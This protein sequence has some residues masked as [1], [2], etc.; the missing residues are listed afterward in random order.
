MTL[1]R[2]LQSETTLDH[3]NMKKMLKLH[4]TNLDLNNMSQVEYERQFNFE[5]TDKKAKA[6]LIK[7]TERK[8]FEVEHKQ[9]S[10][11]LKFS[12]GAYVL[13]AKP[14]IN[15][16]QAM[17]NKK[18][19]FQEEDMV[20]CVTEYKDGMDLNNKHVDTKIVLSVNSKKVV[21]H[22]YNST[23]NIKIDGSCYLQF[24][25][26][27]LAPTIQSNIDKLSTKISEYDRKVH[28]SLAARGRPLRP[29]SVKTVRSFINQPQFICKNCDKKFDNHTQLKKHK[30]TEHSK[31]FISSETSVSYIKHSTRNNSIAEEML[32]C[33]DIT[34]NMD[35]KTL[36]EENRM[37]T[38]VPQKDVNKPQEDVFKQLK[39]LCLPSPS[40]NLYEEDVCEDRKQT[41]KIVEDIQLECIYSCDKCDFESE[42]KKELEVHVVNNIHNVINSNKSLVDLNNV[43]ACNEVVHC[44]LCEHTTNDE[45]SMKLH[46]KDVHGIVDCK[47]CDYSAEDQDILN[48]HMKKH[49]GRIIFTCSICEFEA[50]REFLLENHM[51][52]K[53]EKKPG[54]LEDP[55]CEECGK[56]FPLYFL[57]RY[58][59]C[60]PQYTY[61]CQ[62]CP[63]VAIDI[64][65][66]INHVLMNHV[67]KSE[68]KLKCKECDYST[69]DETTLN[70]HKQ[71]K[72]MSLK[73]DVSIKDQIA[74][75]CEHCDFKCRLNIQ[76]KKH[77]QSVHGHEDSKLRFKCGLCDFESHYVLAMWEHKQTY[78]PEN[79][80]NFQPKSKDMTSTLLAEQGFDIMEEIETL[81]KDIKGSFVELTKGIGMGFVE[82]SNEMNEK[83]DAMKAT[84]DVLNKKMETILTIKEVEKAT[85]VVSNTI[86]KEQKEQKKAKKLENK[87]EQKSS[88]NKK[89]KSTFDVAWVGSTISK[90]MDEKKFE[91]ST[92]SNVKFVRAYGITEENESSHPKAT[93]G[94]PNQ[95]FQ[96]VVPEVINN[97]N[98]DTLVMEAGSIE[99]TNIKVNKAL[100]DTS[101]DIK[102]Y[103]K[104]WFDQVEED[105]K[106]L[107][108]IA[109][110]AIKHKPALK[111]VII[112]RIPRFDCSSQDILGI[113]S[114][115]SNFANSVYDQLWTKSGSPENIKIAELKLNVEHSGYLKSLIFGSKTEDNFDGIHLNGQG[116]SRH[117][118]YRAVQVMQNIISPHPRKP[119]AIPSLHRQP[120]AEKY[121]LCED[122]HSDCPQARYQRRKYSDVVSGYTTPPTAYGYT[123]SVS[124]ANRFNPLN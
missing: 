46:S 38:H 18:I 45:K 53:H 83:F 22:S 97:N 101:K 95:S 60:G 35:D 107:F 78:H 47:K 51:E 111:V 75:K 41:P 72:H 3:L 17:F 81:K 50:T 120:A 77:M 32:P 48:N 9:R 68:P 71:T 114:T 124:T 40:E 11:N 16:F 23:Q 106:K 6:N 94:F 73:I 108:K 59:I 62:V 99:I 7:S 96:K 93:L 55:Q 79:L 42:V 12:A 10:T 20:I 2:K 65:E 121:N 100:M 4:Q 14:M 13:V 57:S 80:P 27:F 67:K 118:T 88:L 119:S 105:S 112:K 85:K 5:L 82:T 110:D 116:A 24:I 30:F 61:P 66:I 122:D 74:I 8:H 113:R 21:L 44:Y 37:I 1:K 52:M 91:K 89:V 58:H 123:Y 31:S 33:E 26:R 87:L 36:E 70:S 104:Q 63:F 76:L 29:R 102:E 15:E 69:L 43:E 98:I 28:T 103:K 117:F 86:E 109:E 39:Q 19:G 56:K 25:E 90:V 49:T 64:E 54:L 92:K 115:L 84:L 34:I